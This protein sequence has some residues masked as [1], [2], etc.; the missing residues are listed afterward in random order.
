MAVESHTL[1]GKSAETV[2]ALVVAVV[3]PESTVAAE[4]SLISLFN[5]I[6]DDCQNLIEFVLD[7]DVFRFDVRQSLVQ[8][9]V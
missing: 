5:F 4:S 2:Q 9:L 6:F 7:V 3:I 1:A 8:G